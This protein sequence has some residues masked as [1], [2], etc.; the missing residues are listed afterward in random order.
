M[1]KLFRKLLCAIGKHKYYV[2][3]SFDNY[4]RRLGCKYCNGDW[5]MND[6]VRCVIDWDGDL[7]NIKEM[8]GHKVN[9]RWQWEKRNE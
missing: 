3:Q 2:H 1:K 5:G 9:P 7:S 4:S 6:H 8:Q